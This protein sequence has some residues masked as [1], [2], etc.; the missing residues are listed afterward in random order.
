MLASKKFLE[1]LLSYDE[2]LLG[3]RQF[4]QTFSSKDLVI[5]IVPLYDPFGPTV[6]QPDID[7]LVVS[8][9]TLPGAQTSKQAQ[10]YGPLMCF[11]VNRIR[12]EN[13]MSP[14]VVVPVEFVKLSDGQRISSSLIRSHSL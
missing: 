8:E 3:V 1:K 6:T 7:V 9:E 11:L 13:G 4:A 12:E 5:D 2:R 14:L 10:F